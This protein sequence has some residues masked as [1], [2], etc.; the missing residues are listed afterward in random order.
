MY[1]A[2]DQNRTCVL[3]CPWNSSLYGDNT[4]KKCVATCPVG[5]FADE[6]MKICTQLCSMG[7]GDN[8]TRKC[9]M[10]CPTKYF[11]DDQT[12]MCVLKCPN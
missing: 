8:T 11:A 1:F 9:V 6:M 2:E 4:T 5:Y 3:S 7:Y 10:N 12:R